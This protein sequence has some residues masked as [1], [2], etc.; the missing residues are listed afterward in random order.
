MI[1]ASVKW[2]HEMQF[3]G[4]GNSG[5]SLI[6]DGDSKAACSPMELVLVALCGCTAYDVVSILKKKREPFTAVEVSAE[7]EKAPE[8]PRVYT[9]IKLRYRVRGPVTRKA[10]EDAVRLSEEKYCSVAAMLNKT[11]KIT[12]QIELDSR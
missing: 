7:A 4:R 10:V 3:E 9:E 5:H 1:A 11:A 12:Y 2:T 8:A 6:L